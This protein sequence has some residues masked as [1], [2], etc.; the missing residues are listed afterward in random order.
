MDTT[1]TKSRV[2][3]ALVLQGVAVL[4]GFIGILDALSIWSAV[5]VTNAGVSGNLGGKLAACVGCILFAMLMLVCILL[6]R[7]LR[8]D[9][10][11]AAP[12]TIAMPRGVTEAAQQ[13]QGE[14]SDTLEL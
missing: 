2:A 8:R 9:T 11:T 12:S 7:K 14:D 1:T 13:F 5:Q 6:A 10:Y 4:T 3:T